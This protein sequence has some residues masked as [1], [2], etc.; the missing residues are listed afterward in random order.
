MAP[1]AEL[2]IVRPGFNNFGPSAAF[3]FAFARRHE[4]TILAYACEGA[5]P[6]V[7]AEIDGTPVP[8]D[9]RGRI[10]AVGAPNWCILSFEAASDL[11]LRQL[12]SLAHAGLPFS[13]ARKLL[14]SRARFLGHSQGA[15]EGLLDRARLASAGLPEAIG[16]VVGLAPPSAGAPIL[17]DPRATTVV[18]RGARAAAGPA[19]LKAIEDLASGQPIHV[20]ARHGAAPAQF[21]RVLAS[22]IGSGGSPFFRSLGW[23][24]ARGSKGWGGD[25]DGLVSVASA[26]SGVPGDRFH[27]YERDADHDTLFEDPLVPDAALG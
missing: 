16:Q 9:L 19:A 1:D 23:I 26:R 13:D 8:G 25:S 4:R 21:D 6:R 5:G 14:T 10:V 22:R 24:A 2:G 15:L 12:L 17:R 27:L 7:C 20:L 18:A 11:F 3:V